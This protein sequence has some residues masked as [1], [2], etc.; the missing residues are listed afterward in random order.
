MA[1][2]YPDHKSQWSLIQEKGY[3]FLPKPFELKALLKT[4]QAVLRN[5]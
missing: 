2:G 3:H 5:G 4:L 1:S